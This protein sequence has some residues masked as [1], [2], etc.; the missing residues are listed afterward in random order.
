MPEGPEC[1]GQFSEETGTAWRSPFLYGVQR[2]AGGPDQILH[3]LDGPFASGG[4]AGEHKGARPVQHAVVDV[5]HLRTGWDRAL[6]HG[7]EELGHQTEGFAPVPAPL[8]NVLLNGRQLPQRNGVAQIPSGDADLVGRLYDLVQPVQTLPVLNLGHDPDP[9]QA[10]PVQRP[11][12]DLY[13]PAAADKGLKDVGHAEFFRLPQ[14]VQIVGCEGGGIY[15]GPQEGQALFTEQRSAPQNMAEQDGGGGA[16][17]LQQQ[18]AV[19]NGQ[20]LARLGG[21]QDILGDGNAAVAQQDIVPLPQLD[22]PGEFS[23][24]QLRPLKVQDKVSALQARLPG[25]GPVCPV[26]QRRALGTLSSDELTF[27]HDLIE[28]VFNCKELIHNIPPGTGLAQSS[29]IFH[30]SLTPF[31][32]FIMRPE[33]G[34]VNGKFEGKGPRSMKTPRAF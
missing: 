8:C 16:L 21:V 32:L 25:G 23:D 18:G 11:P 26:Q 2:L 7:P 28:K 34:E 19:V 30:R 17:D 33:A 10:Q 13:V 6:L 31:P 4:L 29:V 22:R 9:V 14:V 5:A 3:G 24:A 1:S 15:L 20:L 12:Q 27:T